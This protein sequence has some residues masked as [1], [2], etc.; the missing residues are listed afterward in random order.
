MVS[1]EYLRR[2]CFPA[3]CLILVVL[4]TKYFELRVSMPLLLV[5]WIFVW[6]GHQYSNASATWY[7][8][9]N[10]RINMLYPWWFR[11]ITMQHSIMETNNVEIH[12]H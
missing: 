10:K 3:S 1:N 8:E 11:G 7:I 6:T 9:T 4:Q 2:V 5:P 12:I